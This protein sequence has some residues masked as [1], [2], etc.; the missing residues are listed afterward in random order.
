MIDCISFKRKDAKEALKEKASDVKES[1]QETGSK[2]SE[3]G[4]GEPIIIYLKNYDYIFYWMFEIDV[5][6][7]FKN[8]GEGAEEKLKGARST[9][10]EKKQ[11]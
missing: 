2:I 7:G 3:K 10:A 5:K 1:L 4:K 11:G 9:I 8:L 6:E